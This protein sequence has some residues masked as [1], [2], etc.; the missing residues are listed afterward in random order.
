MKDRSG[1]VEDAEERNEKTPPPSR[2]T[3]EKL[4][5]RLGGPP[6]TTRMPFAEG[7]PRPRLDHEKRTLLIVGAVVLA[8]LLVLVIVIVILTKR[9]GGA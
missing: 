7:R 9:G 4:I 2:R 1:E 6:G 3:P 5:R 8:I